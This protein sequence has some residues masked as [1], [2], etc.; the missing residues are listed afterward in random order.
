MK[1]ATKYRSYSESHSEAPS[2]L[3][4]EYTRDESVFEVCSTT[5]DLSSSNENN[6]IGASTDST[7]GHAGSS[8]LCSTPGSTAP[9][10]HVTFN[11]Q[12]SRKTFKPGGPVSGMKKVSSTQQRKLKKRRRQDSLNSQSS[13]QDD[14]APPKSSEKMVAKPSDDYKNPID[15]KDVISWQASGASTIDNTDNDGTNK[16]TSKSAVRF[17]NSLIFELEN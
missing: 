3:N 2:D 9:V 17:T 4:P 15:M 6:S 5:D 14:Q 1:N 8:S 16:T 7:A 10:K 11:N 12:V 13:D